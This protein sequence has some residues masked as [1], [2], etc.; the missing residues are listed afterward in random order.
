[1]RSRYNT[2]SPTSLMIYL[3]SSMQ[4]VGLSMVLVDGNWR[5]WWLLLQIEASTD[6][7]EACF[8]VTEERRVTGQCSREAHGD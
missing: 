4:H 1:M 5:R 2:S 6:L 3:V 8:I 7:E